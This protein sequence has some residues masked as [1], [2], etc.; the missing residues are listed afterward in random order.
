[1]KICVYGTGVIGGI[2][3]GA[4]ARAG[5]EV[6]AI[7]RG[8]HLAAIQKN[9]L[10]LKKP[11]AESYTVN[12]AASDQPKAFPPQDLVL[13][14]TKQPALTGV[15]REIGPLLKPDTLVGF[16]VNGMF[17]FYGDGFTPRGLTLATQA[18]D[19]EGELHRRIGVERSFGMVVYAGGESHA[20]GVI[21]ASRDLG[22]FTIGAALPAQRGR[23]HEAI[24]EMQRAP[25]LALVETDDIRKAMWPKYSSVVASHITGGLTAGTTAQILNTPDVREIVIGLQKEALAVARAHGFDV[26]FDDTR[27]RTSQST[28]QH[29]VSF[30]QDLERGRQVEID[31]TYQVLQD[32]ARQVEV[33]T[34]LVDTLLPLVRLRARVAGC[35]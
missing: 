34:P 35:Y 31:T 33:P 28:S 32:L 21:T 6:C 30:L 24:V 7:A 25:D 3:A 18:L 23:V 26:A 22:D 1:M 29:K 16:A 27:M 4:L 8:A 14:A 17:W 13:I 9:G 10:Q 20:P 15:A 19:P 5:H 11:K 12:I 2:L